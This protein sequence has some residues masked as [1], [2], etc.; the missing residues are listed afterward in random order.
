MAKLQREKVIRAALDLLNEVGVD[1][2]TTRR[3]AD[4]LGVQQPA[5][6]WHFKNKRALLDALAHAMLAE[7]HTHAVPKP[8]EDW[9]SFVTNNAR[10]FRRAL[11]SYR[12]GARI[13]AGTR[14]SGAETANA[15]A[16]LRCLTEAGFTMADT[17]YALMT[18]SYFVVGS[19]MEQ[20]SAQADGVERDETRSAAAV[21]PLL[22]EAMETFDRDGSEAAFERGLS[23]IIAG[24]RERLQR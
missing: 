10:S 17:T 18:I 12:D 23:F 20:Q 16:Q 24:M 22:A 11:L 15:E 1:G 7:R 19:V 6:Y 3:L 9:C 13:H 4:H 14:P 2:L 8:G 5:L 21:S